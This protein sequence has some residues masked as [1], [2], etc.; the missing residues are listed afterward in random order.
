M[1][2]KNYNELTEKFFREF[3]ESLHKKLLAHRIAL[4]TSIASAI[5]LL[6]FGTVQID[7]L[8]EILFIISFFLLII[9]LIANKVLKESVRKEMAVQQDKF[10]DDVYMQMVAGEI[11]GTVKSLSVTNTKFKKKKAKLGDTLKT[12]SVVFSGEY[13]GC[14]YVISKTSQTIVDSIVYKKDTGHVT[15]YKTLDIESA[16]DCNYTTKCKTDSTIIVSAYNAPDSI[17][18]KGTSLLPTVKMDN[19]NF[20]FKVRCDNDVEAYKFLTADVMEDITAFDSIAKIQGFTVNQNDIDVIANT[21]LVNMNYT[22]PLKKNTKTNKKNITSES[23]LN[24]AVSDA[25]TIREFLNS[26]PLAATVYTN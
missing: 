5:A 23:I 18:Q 22:V 25:E 15:S 12:R 13:K 24:D 3:D 21:M 7:D 9:S 4:I 8:G 1:E 11:G 2:K 14:P 6:I 26:I 10:F 16:I 19:K 17:F 20:K